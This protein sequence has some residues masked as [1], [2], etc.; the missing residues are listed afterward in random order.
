MKRFNLLGVVLSAALLVATIGLTL[1]RSVEAQGN[2]A[3][4]SAP[5]TVVNTPLPIRNVDAPELQPFRA[6]AKTTFPT[7]NTQFLL[8][9]VPAGKQLVVEEI[10]WGVA[11]P[12][13]EQFVFG[14]LRAGESGPVV[15]RIQINPP[16]VSLVSEFI[17]QDGSQPARLYF[18]AGEQV[19]A[20]VSA[21]TTTNVEMT[22]MISGHFIDL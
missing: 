3:Q 18:N 19:W 4:G 15:S 11:A 14:A 6:N 5:V 21:T 1:G 12:T 2:A 7:L 20:A 9:T 13:G 16:H 17:L 8:A 22:I 10:S